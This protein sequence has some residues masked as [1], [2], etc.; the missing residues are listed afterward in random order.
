MKK[1]VLLI[2]FLLA[3]FPGC[4]S[5]S[6]D[7]KKQ[8]SD[9]PASKDSQKRGAKQKIIGTPVECP[10]CGLSFSEHEATKKH[11]YKGKTYY[12]LLEDHHDAFL[13]DPSAFLNENGNEPVQQN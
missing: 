6:E 1:L 9:I 11:K 4:Q 2:F 5:N 13:K 8:T 3:L 12:F 10:V 7:A